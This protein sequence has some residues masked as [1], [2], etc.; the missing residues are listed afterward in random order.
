MSHSNLQLHYRTLFGMVSNH[1]FTYSDIEDM[2]VFEK[3]IFISLAMEKVK[4]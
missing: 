1:G 4:G 3:D 2:L